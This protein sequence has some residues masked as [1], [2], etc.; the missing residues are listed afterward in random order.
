[1]V[2]AKLEEIRAFK[3]VM[4]INR[5]SQLGTYTAILNRLNYGKQRWN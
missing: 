2:G 5:K 1:M 4:K 3:I